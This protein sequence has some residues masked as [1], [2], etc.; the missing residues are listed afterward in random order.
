MCVY[1]LFLYIKKKESVKEKNIIFTNTYSKH[2]CI[3]VG[4][5]RL[6]GVQ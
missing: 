5:P 4:H 2:E 3:Q 6:R 1:I